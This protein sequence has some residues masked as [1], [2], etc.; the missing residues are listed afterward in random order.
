MEFRGNYYSHDGK[1]FYHYLL[2]PVKELENLDVGDEMIVSPNTLYF[3]FKENRDKPMII[4]L[5]TRIFVHG[6]KPFETLKT[7]IDEFVG[8]ADEKI[9][10]G[11]T[12]LGREIRP[13]LTSLPTGEEIEA[14]FFFIE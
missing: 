13:E 3:I 6:E 2:Y 1:T 10:R 7:F 12:F 11:E 8:L 14:Y 4:K 5:S 9:K